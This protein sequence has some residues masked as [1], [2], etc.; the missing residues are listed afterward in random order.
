MHILFKGS[1]KGKAYVSCVD[2]LCSV[3][4]V[5][6]VLGARLN[7]FWETW[8]AL[9]AGPKVIQMLKEG[10]TLP[11]QTTPNITSSP[12]I[13]SCYVHP[14][15]NLYVLE[16]F[17]Q[18]TKKNAVAVGQK[19]RISWLLQPVIF[20]PKTRQQ[21]KTYTRSK[22]SQQIPQGR[23]I[24]NGDSRN[25]LY[26]QTGECVM[27]IYFKDAYFH[28]PIQTQ[29]RKYLRFHVQDKTYQFKVLPFGLS[30]AP[31]SSL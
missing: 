12:T 30:T 23:K 9:G 5:P 6:N 10:Y 29:S 18:L 21:R 4:L 8:A 31:L 13:I 22:Q 15:R 19:S 1:H 17:H 27:S 7:Q 14:H 16:A 24:Q 25:S 20:G 2:Q 28:I 3:K 11:F 26:L